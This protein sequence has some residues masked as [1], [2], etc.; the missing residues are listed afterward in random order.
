MSYYEENRPWF[1]GLSIQIAIA[2]ILGF[3]VLGRVTDSVETARHR[4]VNEK[5]TLD[6]LFGADLPPEPSVVARAK[7]EQVRLRELVERLERRVAFERDEGFTTRD[8]S[9]RTEFFKARLAVQGEFAR[10]QSGHAMPF[11]QDLG[12]GDSNPEGE[13]L[14]DPCESHEGRAS[15]EDYIP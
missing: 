3:F 14:D 15:A 13:E 12:F 1:R 10:R 8:V 4:G 5:V 6:S 9:G 2:V 7:E 11:P